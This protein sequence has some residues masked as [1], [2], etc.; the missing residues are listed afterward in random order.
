MQP[1]QQM[2]VEIGNEDMYKW[3]INFLDLNITHFNNV[4]LW[5][6]RYTYVYAYIYIFIYIYKYMY[7]C[8][9]IHI[10]IYLCVY[11][12]IYKYSFI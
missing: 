5:V 3:A 12:Y 7:I 9:N 8:M 10:C 4:Y 2:R 1:L 11:T 6:N